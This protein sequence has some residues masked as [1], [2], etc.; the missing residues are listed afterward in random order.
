MLATGKGFQ[1]E[2]CAHGIRVEFTFCGG[3]A[4]AQFGDGTVWL[5]AFFDQHLNVVAADNGGD[6]YWATRLPFVAFE[7]IGDAADGVNSVV[8][9]VTFAVAV[10]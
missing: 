6:D 4:F 1:F 2:E 5:V 9:Q 7:I 10:K 3:S 8:P